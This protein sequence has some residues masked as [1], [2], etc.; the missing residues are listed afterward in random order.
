VLLFAVGREV[1]L[2]FAENPPAIVLPAVFHWLGTFRW[3]RGM[4][5]SASCLQSDPASRTFCEEPGRYS[6]RRSF[7]HAP[8]RPDRTVGLRPQMHRRFDTGSQRVRI[9]IAAFSCGRKSIC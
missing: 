7:C 8:A 1:V 9:W 2:A 3:L 4:V 5:G 6:T